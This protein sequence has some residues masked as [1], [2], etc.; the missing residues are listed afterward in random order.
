[1]NRVSRILERAS[2]LVRPASSEEA[3]VNSLASSLLAK[4]AAAASAYPETRGALLGGSFAKGTWIP[5]YVDLDIFVRLDPATPEDRFESIGLAVGAAATKG[6]PR[7]KK[8]A[9]HPYT[10]AIAD[11]IRVNIVPCYAV[12][13]KQWKSAADRSPFHV[14]LVRALPE[15]KKTQVRLLKRF[16]KAVGV[17]GA[18]IQTQGFSGY[19]AEVLIINHG[20][21]EGALRWFA[22][23]QPHSSGRQFVL[24]D[25]VDDNRDLA[26]AVSAEKLGRMVLASRDFLRSPSLAFFHRMSGSAR[27]SLRRSVFAVVFS[28]RRMSEDTLWGELRKTSKHLVRHLDVRGFKV[29]R[30][31]S[32]SNNEDRSAILII[33][34]FATL[35]ELEQRVG[36]TVDRKKDVGAFISANRR[37][38]RLVWVDEDARVRLLRPRN[39]TGLPELLKDIA[40]GRAGQ[41]G[42]SRQLE[43]AMKRSAVVLHGSSLARAASSS[44]WLNDGIREI[45]SDALG[46]RSS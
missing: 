40:K 12:E 33:P 46:T 14:D 42:A 23:F 35:P 5:G 21:L 17:Y 13:M 31:L 9:Q 38:S 34:E 36:P 16:M 43:R 4:T 6:L 3:E 11:G 44:R 28:H 10:E 32:A 20:D 2:R 25:P 30:S 24:P 1:L 18:E 45:V 15:E 39:Y 37:D 8:Y 27:P 22:D 7:G 29:A 19:V 26:I 41:V